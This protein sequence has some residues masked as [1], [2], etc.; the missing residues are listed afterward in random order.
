MSRLYVTS[1]TLKAA[2]VYLHETLPPGGQIMILQS[3]W[4]FLIKYQSVIIQ[5]LRVLRLQIALK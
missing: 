3:S 1:F 5:K 4:S 2:A